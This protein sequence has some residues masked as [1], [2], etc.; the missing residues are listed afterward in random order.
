MKNWAFHLSLRLPFITFVRQK[1]GETIMWKT[2][3]KWA[4]RLLVAGLLLGLT[5]QG[6]A[7]SAHDLLDSYLEWVK[8][9]YPKPDDLDRE[10]LFRETLWALYNGQHEPEVKAL[11]RRTV[12]TVPELLPYAEWLESGQNDPRLEVHIPAFAALARA[13][14]KQLGADNVTTGWCRLLAL[15]EKGVMQNVT[16]E[17]EQ[18]TADLE[19]QA[20][21]KPDRGHRAL[22]CAARLLT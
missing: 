5:V 19:R 16:A 18:L 3:K 1:R 17:M 14:G 8:T 6:R 11:L 9:N 20:Q 13:A 10:G 2:G 4:G 22:L 7:Q 21:R 12:Q 15:T